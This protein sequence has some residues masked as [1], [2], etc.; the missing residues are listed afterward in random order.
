MAFCVKDA[1]MGQI[2]VATSKDIWPQK[3]FLQGW[4]VEAGKSRFAA[5]GFQASMA[6]IRKVNKKV[7][8]RALGD[9]I[10]DK[11]AV[12]KVAIADEVEIKLEKLHA[13]AF[14]ARKFEV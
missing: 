8:E 14:D 5:R 3:S 13:Q 9:N 7:H 2:Q 4:V 11:Q 1:G 10:S 6:S 12:L